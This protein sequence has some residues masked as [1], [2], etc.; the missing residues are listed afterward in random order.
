M[1]KARTE[2]K[3]EAEQMAFAASTASA[4]DS[5]LVPWFQ[6]SQRQLNFRQTHDPY[7]IAVSE[8]MLQQ[9]TVAAVEPYYDRFME[10]F[11]SVHDL[12]TATED[13]VLQFWAGL[14]YY[15]RARQLRSAA[16]DVIERWGG[17]F[18]RSVKE[19]QSLPGF[20]RY[21]AGAVCSFAFD[22]PAPVL[23]ANTVRVF[24]RLA[25][26]NGVIGHAPYMHALWAV[27]T[28]LVNEAESPRLFNLAAMELGALVCK[29]KPRC[30]ICPVQAWC[31]AYKRGDEQFI[32][33]S[34][35]RPEKKHVSMVCAAISNRSGHY[36]VRRIPKGEWHS[37]LWEFPTRQLTGEH[38]NPGAM[39]ALFLPTTASEVRDFAP[40]GTLKYTVTHHQ[41]TC[42]IFHCHAD[43]EAGDVGID[44][45]ESVLIPLDKI[46]KLAMGSAQRKLL[47]LL[48]SRA[49]EG[50]TR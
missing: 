3:Q 23:E 50:T 4:I 15:R 31:I 20:G 37:G 48:V 25:G 33:Q 43:I 7:S 10:R 44:G 30:E 42:H 49:A 14:G 17:E 24:A 41:I 13:E 5:A 2:N 34:R 32:P 1:G 38:V 12:A 29:P 27:S 11:P 28:S 8:F 26:H 36:L 16:I 35:P 6:K 45:D 22:L 21:T 40:M 39:K 46:E 18:P 19:L 47:K 9:T